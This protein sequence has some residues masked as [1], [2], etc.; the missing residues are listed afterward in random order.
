MNAEEARAR[1]KQS[2]ENVTYL[3]EAVQNVIRIASAAG[4]RKATYRAL[5]L[6]VDDDW[7]SLKAIL[8]KEGFRIDRTEVDPFVLCP[9]DRSHVIEVEW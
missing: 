7:W 8:E 9:A 5:W 3:Y 6:M 1:S 2:P 4:L